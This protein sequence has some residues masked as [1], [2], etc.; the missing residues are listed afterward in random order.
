MSEQASPRQLVHCKCSPEIFLCSTSWFQKHRLTC[1]TSHSNKARMRLS[2]KG[3]SFV[4]RTVELVFN[5]SLQPQG[6]GHSLF[7]QSSKVFCFTNAL[8]QLTFPTLGGKNVSH[9]SKSKPKYPLLCLWCIKSLVWPWIQFLPQKTGGWHGQYIQ[10][11]RPHP[12]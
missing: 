4:L 11:T 5:A 3:G 1:R 12:G 6:C 8:R 2:E 9:T 10:H 7:P